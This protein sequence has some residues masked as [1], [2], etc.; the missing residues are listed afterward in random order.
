MQE[1]C[2]RTLV[3]EEIAICRMH[4][5]AAT[6]CLDDPPSPWPQ[7]SAATGKRVAVVGAGP[8]GLPPAYVPRARRGT[9]VK[10][11]MMQPQA[12]GMLRYGHPGDR[13]PKDIMDEEFDG[14]WKLG[15]EAQYDV[16]L[17]VDFTIDDPL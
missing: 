15:V 1:D 10:V 3:E 17:G 14:V 12:G 16:K 5:Y 6:Q 7:G 11:F 8:S 2:R 13:L 4:G 9:D